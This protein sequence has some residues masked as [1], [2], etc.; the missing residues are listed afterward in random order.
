MTDEQPE[1]GS[2]A[3]Y[4]ARIRAQSERAAARFTGRYADDDTRTRYEAEPYYDTRSGERVQLVATDTATSY[5]VAG[6]PGGA[7]IGGQPFQVH[8]YHLHVAY[9]FDPADVFDAINTA[10]N[11]LA[12]RLVSA[13]DAALKATDILRA[14]RRI[15]P[16]RRTGRRPPVV[17]NGRWTWPRTLSRPAFSAP[18]RAPRWRAILFRP[19]A[20]APP[21]ALRG[22][23]C[24]LKDPVRLSTDGVSLCAW[25]R[26]IVSSSS[27]SATPSPRY[28][29]AR[30]RR[31]AANRRRRARQTSC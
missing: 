13:A 5:E 21:A 10:M 25:C 24:E 30:R 14:F 11:R 17:A 4:L 7:Q 9:A 18:L 27:P 16:P 2:Y 31:S 19:S 15:V 23:S 3:D 29:R 20:R 28:R 22:P 1:P 6:G 26:A 8:G 12:V